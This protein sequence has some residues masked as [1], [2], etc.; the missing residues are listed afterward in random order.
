MTTGSMLY[1]LMCLAMFGAFSAA[2]AYYSREAKPEKRPAP[3]A[4]PDTKGAVTG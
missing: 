3:A 1:L 4:R 2:L